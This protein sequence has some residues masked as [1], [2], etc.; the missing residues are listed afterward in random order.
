MT[1]PREHITPALEELHWLPVDRRIE[2]KIVM[3]AN[4]ALNGLALEY[5][6]DMVESY[7]PDRALRSDSQNLLVLPRGKHC[8]YGIL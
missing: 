6:C 2:Y 7:A 5:L 3:Y 1:A 8:Q 4:K